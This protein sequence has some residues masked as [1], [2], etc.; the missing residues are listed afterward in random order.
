MNIIISN[1]SGEPIYQQIESQ[2]KAMIL[3]GELS[4]GETLPSMRVLSKELRISMIT[5]KRAYEEL[6]K[7]GFI[8]TVAG[9]GSFVAGQNLELVKEHH[10]KEIEE[11]LGKAVGLSNL[12]KLDLEQLKEMLEIIYKGE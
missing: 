4:E 12:C 9:K 10:L 8:E 3:N 5:T 6:E 2:I 7:S 11:L 1:S